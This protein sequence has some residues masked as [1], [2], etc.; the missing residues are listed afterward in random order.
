M[1]DVSEWGPSKNDWT[2]E[3]PF[4]GDSAT[5][6]ALGQNADGRLELFYVGTDSRLY[7]RWQTS[8][9]GGLS[10]NG[11]TGE[12]LFPGAIDGAKP[13]SA[14]SVAV[15]QNADGRLELFY[16]T[17]VGRLFHRWQTS[18]NGGPSKNDWT[19]EAAFPSLSNQMRFSQQVIQNADGRLEIFYLQQA[20]T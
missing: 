8:L 13:G 1:A 17:P 18:P 6:I 12:V 19:G 3:T 16:S 2:G 9:G 15:G 5:S 4:S 20:E 14:L 11:W 10:K 7:H